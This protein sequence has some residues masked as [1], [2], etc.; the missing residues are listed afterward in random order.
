MGVSECFLC[1]EVKLGM[2]VSPQGSNV[3]I[4]QHVSRSCQTVGWT[5]QVANSLQISSL[6]AGDGF[7]W[8]FQPRMTLWGE[9]SLRPVEDL[10]MQILGIRS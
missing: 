9:S 6:F 4:G 1:Q 5:P 2:H 7:A 3:S 10:K 8:S